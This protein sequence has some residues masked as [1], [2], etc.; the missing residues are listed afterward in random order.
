MAKTPKINV[1]N[2]TEEDKEMASLF[3]DEDVKTELNNFLKMNKDLKKS[4]VEVDV[5]NIR[6]LVQAYY[7]MQDMRIILSG[8][9]RSIEQGTSYGSDKVGEEGIPHAEALRWLYNN[10]LGLENE[11]KKALDKWS[12]AD[13]VAYWAKQVTGIGPVISSGLVTMFDIEKA[14]AVSHFYSYAG[15]NDNNN[16]WLGKVKAEAL[17]KKYCE[18]KEVTIPELVA[19]SQDPE[20][21][22]RSMDKLVRYATELDKKK[23]PTGKYTREALIKG[24]AKPPYNEEL[25]VLLWKLG[26]SFIKVSNRPASVYGRIYQ[27]KKAIETAKN[28]RGEFAEQ[29]AQILSSKKFNKKTKSYEAYSQGKLPDAQITA[30]ASRYATKIFVSHLW[31]EMYRLRYND[32]APRPYPIAFLGHVDIMAPEVPYTPLDPSKPKLRPSNPVSRY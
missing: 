15:L 29:A 6:F 11:V 4:I 13:P 31:E 23:K 1:T 32:E 5:N 22:Y 8:R 20:C 12:D 26:Q 16:P 18:N 9:I 28:E 25:K 24:L 2:V 19:L 7:Q 10:M 3:M 17:V 21:K 14:P 30:R 27:E